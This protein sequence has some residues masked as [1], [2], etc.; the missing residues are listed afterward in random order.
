MAPLTNKDKDLIKTLVFDWSV[1]RM[2]RDFPS[3]KLQK[4]TLCNLIKHIVETGKIH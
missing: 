1:L 2:I 4:S 3:Q